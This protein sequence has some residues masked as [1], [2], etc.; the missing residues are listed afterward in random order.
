MRALGFDVDKDEVRRLMTEFDVEEKGQIDHD[1]FVQIMAEKYATRSED[2]EISEAFKLFAD[3]GSKISLKHMRRVA[4]ELGETI[5]EE[6]L[7]AMIDEFDRDQD[8]EI[9]EEEFNY[10]MKQ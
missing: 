3:D 8:G 1:A 9:N 6:E 2:Q 10:I 4:R 7:R 5:S